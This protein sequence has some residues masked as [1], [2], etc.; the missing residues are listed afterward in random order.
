MSCCS[1][2][3]LPCLDLWSLGSNLS[4][5]KNCCLCLMPSW[6]FI[7][8]FARGDEILHA[9]AVL[10]ET[11]HS[12]C[13]STSGH[14]TG[15][16]TAPPLTCPGDTLT[17]SCT[18][19]GSGTTI[20]TVSGGGN[21]CILLHSSSSSTD[22]CGPSSVFIASAGTGFGDENATSFTSTLSATATSTLDGVTVE[23][24]GPD[25]N[26]NPGNRVGSSNVQIIGTPIVSSLMRVVHT[27]MFIR[28]HVTLV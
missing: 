8:H 26:Q 5:R 14:V 28:E 22:T 24:F 4:S 25:S 7:I 15:Q 9:N 1:N 27:C 3:L 20:W 19:N 12:A 18:V 17:F 23:C 16:L 21:P 13:I 2:Y 10:H 6:K 11:C